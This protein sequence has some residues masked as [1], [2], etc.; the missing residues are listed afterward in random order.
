MT[1]SDTRSTHEPGDP[2][3]LLPE[4]LRDPAQTAQTDGT[5]NG[6]AQVEPGAMPPP[7]VEDQRNSLQERE[8][9]ES[10]VASAWK[11]PPARHT[12]TYDPS[13]LIEFEDLPSWMQRLHKRGRAVG[14][15]SAISLPARSETPVK[16]FGQLDSAVIRDVDAT[17]KLPA[18]AHDETPLQPES[19]LDLTR[20][21]W[22]AGTAI[23]LII[24]ALIVLFG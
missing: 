18:L 9:T 12:G 13:T 24:A 8:A 14:A 23:V 2:R 21:V 11:Q 6:S 19:D 22:I 5:F 15:K 4:W 20:F 3:L 7:S 1:P 10:I 17:S 16:V